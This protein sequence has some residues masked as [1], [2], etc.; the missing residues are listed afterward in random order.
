MSYQD[1]IN[2][3]QATSEIIERQ[4]S[5]YRTSTIILASLLSLSVVSLS[6]LAMREHVEPFMVSVDKRTGEVALPSKLQVKDFTP[7]KTMVRHFTHQ[8]INNYA[9]YNA[10][11]IKKPF[12]EVLAMSDSSVREQYKRQILKSNPESPL[13]ILGRSRYQVVKIHSISELSI[14]NT[15]DVR[16]STMIKDSATDADLKKQEWRA[17][18]KWKIDKAKHSI[19]ELNANPISFKVTYLDVQPVK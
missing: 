5:L 18:L 12:M 2:F 6:G 17:V 19:E 10:L 3:K 9:S 16:Y 11:N 13:N 8:F 14:D 7:S 1:A 15:L 4:I